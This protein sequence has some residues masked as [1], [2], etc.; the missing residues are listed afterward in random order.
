[1]TPIWLGTSWKMNKPLSQAMAWC[2]T[3]AARMPEGCHPA[4]QPFVIPPFTAIQPVSHFLQMHQLPLL[5]GAQ[6]MH[7]ADQGA[8]TGEISAAMLAETGATLVELGH[9]ERRAAFNESDAAINRKVHS[10]LG[11]GLRPL[12]CIGDSAEEKRWQVSRESVVRQMKIALYGLSHQQALQI[13]IA[14]EPVWAIGEHG[15]P[16]S[17]QE[18]GVIHQALREALCER[19][20]HETGIRIPLLYGGSVTLQNAVELLRQPEINGLLSAARPGTH[21][22]IATLFNALHRNLF[23]KRS[24]IRGTP[25]MGNSRP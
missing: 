3:L 10:A 14:Y 5:T 4:I 6:N 8:W 17:P 19:F 15:T 11:H 7:E 1:M 25:E 9:S 18:A 21:K 22:A 20:G 23:C 24:N 2:E 12:I 16:A 13:L